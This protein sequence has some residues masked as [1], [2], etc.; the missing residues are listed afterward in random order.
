MTTSADPMSVIHN[1]LAQMAARANE[2]LDLT[3]AQRDVLR[4]RVRVA[5]Q[6][7]LNA[8]MI[9]TENDHNTRDTAARVA[10]MYVDEVFRGRYYPAPEITTF[11]NIDKNDDLYTLGPMVVRSAC[12][13]HL[14]PIEGKAWVALLPGEK[15]IGISKL[16][17][18]TEWFMSRPQIQEEAVEQ[19]ANWLE[20]HLQ[21]RGLMVVVKARHLCMSWRGVKEP[22]SVM[23]NSS[24]RGEFRSNPSL[25][26]EALRLMGV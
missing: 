4:A 23:T 19:I 7:L 24:C 14:V 13:H 9:D 21:P 12:S 2:N 15:L 1:E 20:E 16:S 18:I 11:P 17:R 26:A 8:L 6:D 3:D 25:K 5:V 22:E 10:K